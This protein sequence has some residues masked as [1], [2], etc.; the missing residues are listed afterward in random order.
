[1]NMKGGILLRETETN[2]SVY[3]EYAEDIIETSHGIIEQFARPCN[4]IFHGL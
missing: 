3:K 4:E 2:R 1:M